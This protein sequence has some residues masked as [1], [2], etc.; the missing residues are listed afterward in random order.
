[1]G[2][3]NPT[4]EK[5]QAFMTAVPDD[6]PLVMINLL[7]Y[8][9]EAAYPP[10]YEGKPCSGREAY[11]TYSAA[12]IGYVTAVNGRVL[13][14]GQ[15]QLGL[16]APEEESWDDALLVEYPSKQ[17]FLQM[18]SNPEYHTITVHRT[19]ALEDSRLLVTTTQTSQ[20]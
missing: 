13:W 20:L 11:Q 9:K 18:F 3:I 14:L 19:A 7:K 1:M 8:R 10:E 16:I 12:A 17:A 2:T 4:P 6:T 15:V 5:L